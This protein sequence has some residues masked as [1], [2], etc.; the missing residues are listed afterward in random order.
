MPSSNPQLQFNQLLDQLVRASRAGDE[1]LLKRTEIEA[2]QLLK[3]DPC[4][5]YIALGALF[6]VK[7]NARES[8]S[9][10]EK[11]LTLSRSA[12]T[13][14]NYGI[15]LG[16][17]DYTSEALEQIDLSLAYGQPPSVLALAIELCTKS[18]Q[19]QRA[20]HYYQKLAKISP[21][22]SEDNAVLSL[23]QTAE[24]IKMCGLTD[25]QINE[26]HDIYHQVSREFGE[27]IIATEVWTDEWS[28]PDPHKPY[29]DLVIEFC[30][31]AKAPSAA[32]NLRA[33]DLLIEN[34]PYADLSGRY[35]ATFHGIGEA[36][37]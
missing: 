16:Y 1:I 12:N 34:R 23:M 11:S 9:N 15:S 37:S 5:A 31:G 27:Q 19:P 14:L 30:V 8:I 18:G 36:S 6:A 26:V 24:K 7:N 20:E 25:Q 21:E 32:M 17:L 33:I 2:N 28:D 35:F 29:Q 3:S 4:G 22:A 13:H 10:H